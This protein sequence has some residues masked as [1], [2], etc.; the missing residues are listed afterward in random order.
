G[1]ETIRQAG[2][3]KE[4]QRK[5]DA[6]NHPLVQAILTTFPGATIEAVRELAGAEPEAD[7]AAA[8]SPDFGESEWTLGEDE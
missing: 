5:K 6:A 1:A 8:P 3:E 4:I 2:I 7:D